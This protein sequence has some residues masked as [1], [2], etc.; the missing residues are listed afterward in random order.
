MND[1][2]RDPRFYLVNLYDGNVQAF[3]DADQL[4][5]YLKRKH[6]TGNLM[7]GHIYTIFFGQQLSTGR[8]WKSL[9]GEVG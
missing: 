7:S 6:S 4:V 8:Y 2:S 9:L 5:V 3:D 1:D